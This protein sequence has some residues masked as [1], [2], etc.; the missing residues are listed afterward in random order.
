MGNIAAVIGEWGVVKSPR[1]CWLLEE[2]LGISYDRV[3]ETRDVFTR[4]FPSEKEGYLYLKSD[5][6]HDLSNIMAMDL[7]FPCRK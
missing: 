7:E 3:Y 1:G 6:S 2:D 4:Y 5:P